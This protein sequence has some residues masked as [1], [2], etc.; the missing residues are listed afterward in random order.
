MNNNK[1]SE[2]KVEPAFHT[3]LRKTST[4]QQW[5]TGIKINKSNMSKVKNPSN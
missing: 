3:T 5:A 2:N 4:M 1:N